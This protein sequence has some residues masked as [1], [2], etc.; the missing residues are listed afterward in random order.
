[1][2]VALVKSCEPPHKIS[3][4]NGREYAP[5]VRFKAPPIMRS[6]GTE[7][8]LVVGRTTFDKPSRLLGGRPLRETG[9]FRE[10]I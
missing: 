2:T 6:A 10:P 5:W 7:S 1:M 4:I 9:K 8:G 3:A